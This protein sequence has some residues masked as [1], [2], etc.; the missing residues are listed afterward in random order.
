M[1]KYDAVFMKHFAQLILGLM[2][3]AFLLIVLAHAI[4]DRFYGYSV[5]KNTPP[6]E[7]NATQRERRAARDAEISA[8]LAPI[9]K[10]NAGDT[11]RA[12]IVA[13]EEARKKAMAGKVAYGGTL[14]GSVIYQQ[15]CGACHQNGA[16]GAPLPTRDAW[17]P[18]IAQG[19][20]TLVTHA[21]EGYQGSAG[22][23]PARGG[24]P[25]LTDEQV[26]ASVQY[27]VDKY[28]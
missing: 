16:G 23:M 13:A 25:S 11:G 10:V 14:D 24:N 5:D 8:R 19:V 12:A 21:I 28:K 1:T 18:R 4:N 6:E 27:M 2:A 9:A 22:I 26:R 20:E 17:A 7:L 15:L 3:F